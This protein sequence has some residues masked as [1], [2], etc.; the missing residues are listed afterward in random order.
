MQDGD[1]E[2]EGAEE[3][4]AHVDVLGLALHQRAEEDDGVADPDDGDQDVDRPF[5]FGVFLRAGVAQRQAHGGQQDDQ[6]PSPEGERGQGV[7]EQP[8]LAGA[9]Y[10]VVGGGE[11][12]AAAEGEDHRIGVQRAQASEARP[13]QVEIEVGP[14]QLRRDQDADGHA[15]DAPYHCHDGELA[16][17]LIV[18]SRLIGCAHAIGLPSTVIG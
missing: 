4:V 6:L 16:D 1:G 14:D 11:Q 10:R 3:P 8:R 17:H 9:L 15:D 2:D 18:I 13:G 12:C 5:Q 7:G